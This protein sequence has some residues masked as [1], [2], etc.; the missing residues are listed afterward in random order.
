M[1]SFDGLARATGLLDRE[2][3]QLVGALQAL[4]RQQIVDLVRLAAQADHQRGVEVHVGGVAAEHAAEEFDGLAGG[5]H[6]TARA[7]G[8]RDDAVDVRILGEDSSVKCL[9]IMRDD[10]RGAVHAGDDPDVVAR[11]D[12]AVGAV[13]ALERRGFGDE[14]GGVVIGTERVV[15]LEAVAHAEVVHV[16][17]LAGADG[18]GG[19]A[20]DL[21]VAADRIALLDVVGGD[22]VPGGH[23]HGRADV[24]LDDLG[25]CGEIDARDDHI[26]GG[27]EADDQIGGL[28]HGVLP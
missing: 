20:D 1:P 5:A 7:V 17:V 24:L 19:E 13:V 18:A 10:V 3:L 28:Q 9:A 15:A 12:A 21:V 16:D 6:A 4:G 8:D 27:I 25:A 11:R 22:L 26:V 14:L 23:G 2:G